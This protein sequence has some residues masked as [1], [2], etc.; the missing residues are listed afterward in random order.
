MDKKEAEVN[1][2]SLREYMQ[3]HTGNKAAR[4]KYEN[5]MRVFLD[6]ASKVRND[7]MNLR[8]H[9]HK[10]QEVIDNLEDFVDLA[11]GNVNMAIR[12]MCKKADTQLVYDALNEIPHDYTW[13]VTA[14]FGDVCLQEDLNPYRKIGKSLF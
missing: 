11:E 6:A 4:A 12:F 2:N 14:A 8:A 3:V 10:L 9:K 5:D 13:E 1:E 7:W